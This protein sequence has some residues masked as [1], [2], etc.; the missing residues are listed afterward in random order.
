MKGTSL[1]LERSQPRFFLLHYLDQMF[2]YGWTQTGAS[3][4]SGEIE[5]TGL[6]KGSNSLSIATRDMPIPVSL[7]EK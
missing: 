1:A 7:T 4:A 3:A 5:E 2:A 6:T